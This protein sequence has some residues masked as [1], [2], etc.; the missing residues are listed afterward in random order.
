M[1]KQI[2]LTNY[3]ML[4]ARQHTP[5]FADLTSGEK[6]KYGSETISLGEANLINEIGKIRL[7]TIGM[8]PR[9]W[10]V[11]RAKKYF[12]IKGNKTTLVG[13]IEA[14]KAEVEGF[15]ARA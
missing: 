2:D 8:T 9:G 15:V 6:V 12:G 5:F 4:N 1:M 11:A 7:W 3:P 10:K 13:Q 14:L